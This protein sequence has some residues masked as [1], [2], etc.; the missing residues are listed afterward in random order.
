[1]SRKWNLFHQRNYSKY[2]RIIVFVSFF[3][4][5]DF[6]TYLKKRILHCS[7][8]YWRKHLGG[9][10]WRV[11]SKRKIFLDWFWLIY[12]FFILRFG[13]TQWYFGTLRIQMEIKKLK[14]KIELTE[15]NVKRN[16]KKIIL[17]KYLWFCEQMVV[18]A[19]MILCK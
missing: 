9:E 3:F 14:K 4:W 7:I 6:F 8:Q 15:K 18:G 10:D 11:I 16:R 13:S 2:W 17:K 5:R 12:I 1:L 19:R